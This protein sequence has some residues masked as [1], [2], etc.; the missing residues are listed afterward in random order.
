MANHL[1][2]VIRGVRREGTVTIDASVT[3]KGQPPAKL[4]R[5]L[6]DLEVAVEDTEGAERYFS[7]PAIV[8]PDQ[9]GAYF[10]GRAVLVAVIPQDQVEVLDKDDPMEVAQ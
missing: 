9:A 3:I 6:L 2:G 1:Q 8:S 7:I 5:L 10:V 4:R